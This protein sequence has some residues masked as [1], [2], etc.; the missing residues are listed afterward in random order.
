MMRATAT[1]AVM[2]PRD[3]P[4]IVVVGVRLVSGGGAAAA[5]ISAGRL[6]EDMLAA[7]LLLNTDREA[8]RD[9]AR[10]AMNGEGVATSPMGAIAKSVRWL[11]AQVASVGA[12]AVSAH[13]SVCQALVA[14]SQ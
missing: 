2:L 3:A 8:V 7:A 1:T 9:C 4:M 12:S 5:T 10:G 13:P 14:V 11:Q 6:L